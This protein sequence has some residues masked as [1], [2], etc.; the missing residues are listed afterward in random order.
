MLAI[1]SLRL[2]LSGRIFVSRLLLT[3][4]L[5]G[6]R[7]K[8]KKRIAPRL[9]VHTEQPIFTDPRW[10]DGRKDSAIRPAPAVCSDRPVTLHT[11]SGPF[12]STPLSYFTLIARHH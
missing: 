7:E 3:L 4:H 6:V 5:T 11:R 10:P 9:F 12:S 8:A 2:K 1:E